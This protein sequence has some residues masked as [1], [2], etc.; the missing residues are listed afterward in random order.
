M[1]TPLALALL[2]MIL[3]PAAR[4]QAGP[5]ASPSLAPQGWT[6]VWSD[7]F[8]GTSIDTLSNWKYDLG[9]GGWGNAEL[10][11]YTNRPENAN[12]ENGVLRIIARKESYGGAS[13]TSA[14]MKTQGLRSFTYGRVEARIK[15]PV[16]QGIWPAFWML[17]TSI[18]QVGWPKC[19]EIDI[20]EHINSTPVANGTMHWDNNGHAQYGTTTPCDVSLYHLYAIE[21]DKD[22]IQ[23]FV[24]SVKYL[25]GNIANNINSTD[26]FHSPF[27]I[28]LN[29]AIGGN[30][31]GN[32]TV[33]TPFPDT[34]SVD[35][36][37]VYQASTNGLREDGIPRDTRLFQN[38]PNPFNPNS[39]I[40][41]QIADSR[42]V[43]LSV[44]DMLGREVAVLVD[45]K[46]EPGEYSVSWKAG[47]MSSGVY[48]CRLNAGSY[49]GTTRMVLMK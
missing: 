24:D 32:P 23:W 35:Y 11:Y 6:L 42:S 22:R 21:W 31:P 14:R 5:S 44:F 45:E 26:E 2:A 27:F 33:G 16:G 25:E 17:G 1:K 4:S 15:L 7:E 18:T 43:R 38:F 41:Y 48:F 34:M 10:E 47:G 29:L 20:M 12:I 13:Y 46:K 39:D 49:A 19:G 40:R 28:I 3:A 9:G 30:W 8:N 37:R 36:V